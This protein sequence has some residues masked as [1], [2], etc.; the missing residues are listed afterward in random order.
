[1]NR[2]FALPTVTVAVLAATGCVGCSPSPPREP[3]CAVPPN[4]NRLLD[5]YAGDPALTFVPDGAERDHPIARQR[6]C[7]RLDKEDVSRTSVETSFT[8]TRDY[9]QDALL[10][11]YG[12]VLTDHGWSPDEIRQAELGP[13]AGQ[14]F[15]AYC[16]VVRGVT[17]ELSI[18]ANPA[19]RYDVRP[20]GPN[21]PPSPQW[22]EAPGVLVLVIE[23]APERSNCE[24]P[25]PS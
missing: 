8:L 15:L 10:A 1:M 21:R 4:E 5:D 14:P 18:S 11:A 20:S 6:G 13:N 19:T 23:A 25:A 7:I 16:R 2:R 9:D 22:Q 24:D 17:T 12:P 3:N